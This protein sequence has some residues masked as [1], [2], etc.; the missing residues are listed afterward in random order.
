MATFSKES[1]VAQA[2]ID[3]WALRDQFAV[4]DPEE[5][6]AMARA[7]NAA[8]AQQGD[9]VELTTRGLETAG[10]GYKV[11]NATPID[12]D[13]EVAATSRS[14]GNNG[15]KLGRIAKLLSETASDLAVRTSTATTGVSDMESA[16]NGVIGR[17][18]TFW[19]GTGHHLPEED[20]KPVRDTYVAEAVQKVKDFGGPIKQSI[21]DY[22]TY[23]Q[24]HLR[25]MADLGYLPSDAADEGPGDVNLTPAAAQADAG[26]VNAALGLPPGK[27][28]IL[29]IQDGSSTVALLNAK[30]AA[31]QPLT[32]AERAYLDAWYNAVGADNLAKIPGYVRAAAPSAVDLSRG[33]DG[34]PVR[35]ADDI[36]RQTVTP[37]AN[38][39][40]NLSNPAVGGHATTAEMPRAIQDL[41]NQRVGY[42][43]PETG[44]RYP[45]SRWT[46]EAPLTKQQWLEQSQAG[47][48]DGLGRYNGFADLMGAADVTG[49]DAYTKDLA[50]SAVRIKQDLNAAQYG[51]RYEMNARG[52]DGAEAA[53]VLSRTVDDSGASEML[54][55]V[56]H[57]HS[58]SADVVLDPKL[59]AEVMGLNWDDEGGAAAVLA[60]GTE[61]SPA[62][63]GGTE[64][65]ARAA[66]AVIQEVGSDRDFYL[67]RMGEQLEDTVKDIGVEY[68]DAFARDPAASSQYRTDLKDPLGRDVGPSFQLTGADRD[69]YLQFVSGTGDDDAIDFQ[70]KA[71][72]YSQIML[73][74]AFRSGSPAQVQEALHQA[75]ALDGA[76][77]QA[78]FDYTFD[79]VDG[80][81]KEAVAAARAASL[82]H[83]A[84]K[85]GLGFAAAVVS[86]GV[87]LAT[88]GAGL[89]AAVAITGAIVTGVAGVTVIDDP[90]P[91][92]DLPRTRD[93]L[94]HD[95]H[96][97]YT[98][99]RD[100]LVLQAALDA[101]VVDPGSL[102]PG[103]VSYDANGHATVVPVDM[104]DPQAQSNLRT[105]AS[106][107]V[108]SYEAAHR[109]ATDSGDVDKLEYDNARGN[110]ADGTWDHSNPHDSRWSGDERY[111]LAYGDNRS[112]NNRPYVPE[113]PYNYPADPDRIDDPNYNPYFPN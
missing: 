104:D 32:P 35:S 91:A 85:T 81:D 56:A 67:N 42:V 98:V 100:A 23:L 57:N 14:L 107:A 60:S 37:I 7:F 29:G 48:V 16:V 69:R 111:R 44:N 97:S 102:P 92:A 95:D 113:D 41:V 68:M 38:G 112:P 50:A 19:Q 79:T 36:Y 47:G 66:L 109:T 53:A 34:S 96:A 62:N 22:E 28:G 101:G 55:V 59:R 11:D 15:E 106:T 89:P 90:A 58:A 73:T 4:G 52:M 13:A 30:V 63:G 99:R 2:G 39:I 103:T 3:P 27:D 49:G 72:A 71:T 76:I 8:A 46:D 78:N 5:I 84:I 94:L 70:A 6:Y 24:A 86:T 17:W 65:Q 61:R 54:G 31:G 110:I 83:I 64:K 26:K 75:G 20:W 77:T 51:A 87:G 82:E 33:P 74:E 25:S 108:N 12:V 9:A 80:T 10:D 105:G 40:M 1:L 45:N 18:N 21:T 43:D 93:Q 88:E